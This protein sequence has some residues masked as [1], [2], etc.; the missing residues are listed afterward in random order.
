M[1][2]PGD[3]IVRLRAS[4]FDWLGGD[5]LAYIAATSRVARLQPGAVVFREGDPPDGCYLILKGAVKVSLV[6]PDGQES[7]LAILGPGDVVG[8][9]ALLDRLPRSA[10]VVALRGCELCHL[11]TAAFER[12]AQTDIAVYRQLLCV[13]SARLRASNERY[14]LQ[15]MGLSGRLARAFLQLAHSC[16]EVLPDR[17]ILIRQKLSQADLG[18]M[19]GAARENVNRQLG[20]WRRHQLLSRISGYYCLKDPRALERLARGDA[21]CGALC[22]SAADGA[23]DKTVTRIT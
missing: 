22:A 10:T 8:E 14:A 12:L 23:N 3:L 9:M 7:L 13:L 21:S 5:T 4:A 11:H 6:E 15:R 1:P 18:H 20:E 17:R 19:I 16:G 2:L